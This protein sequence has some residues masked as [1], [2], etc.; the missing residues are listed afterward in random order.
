MLVAISQSQNNVYGM[1]I[2]IEG[3]AQ[4]ARATNK[5]AAIT[6]P[7]HASHRGNTPLLKITTPVARRKLASDT[8]SV[9]KP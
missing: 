4:N 9:A 7:A 3:A 5:P 2:A 1:K 6:T 8:H